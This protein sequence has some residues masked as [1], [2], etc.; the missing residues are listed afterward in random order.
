[1]EREHQSK[2]RETLLGRLRRDPRDQHA[3]SEFVEHY[4]PKIYQ[5]C[6]AWNMPDADALDVVQN[7]LMQ[8]A[9]KLPTFEYD[10][11]RSFH[12]WLKMLTRHALID[13]L[14]LLRRQGQGTGDSKIR[15]VF[16][17]QAA[18]DDLECRFEQE[19]RNELLRKAMSDVQE[20]VAARTWQAFH[21]TAIDELT[22][23]E[24]AARIPMP[25]EQIYVARHRV[26]KLLAEAVALYENS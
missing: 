9:R 2:T 1:M 16:S 13:Y 8:L 24:A 6:L 23:V 25:I 26:Q 18:R 11:R 3:W 7:V 17:Q 20:R 12:A 21:L 19:A 4:G 10:P 5:W 14:E 15:E 22:A